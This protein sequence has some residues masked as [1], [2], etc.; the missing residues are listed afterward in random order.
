[1]RQR[2]LTFLSAVLLVSC[3]TTDAQTPSPAASQGTKAHEGFYPGWGFGTRFEGSSS[4]DGAVYDIATGVGY[5]FSRHFGV[6]L[7]VPY[8]FVSTPTAI[9]QKNGQAVSGNGLGNVGADLKWIYPEKAL[10]YASTIHLGAPTGDTKKGFSTAHATW[11]WSNHIEHGWGNFTP[12]IDG[13]VGN[14]VPDTKY[15]HRPFTTFGYNAQF[16]AGTEV[17]AGPL[18]LSASLYDIAPWGTQMVV[19]K[20]FRCTS[21]TKCS[22]GAKTTNRKNYLNAN[23]STG[24]AS[25]TRDNGINAGVE[26][27]PEQAKYLDLEFEYSHSV[28]LRLN[29]ISFGVAVD[30]SRLMRSR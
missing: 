17:D 12:F 24:D 26:Y 16:E 7:G 3:S 20:V 28:P 6:D 25:L 23:V 1:M 13:G 14:S 15:F 18:S 30:I 9:K 4:G 22:G 8:N 29:S 2:A 27:K 10:T 19:S 5:N 21:G 11:N